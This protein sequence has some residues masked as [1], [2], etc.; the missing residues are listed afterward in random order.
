M[1]I[2]LF[3]DKVKKSLYICEIKFAYKNNFL[4]DDLNM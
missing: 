4:N 3:T 1:F 2:F